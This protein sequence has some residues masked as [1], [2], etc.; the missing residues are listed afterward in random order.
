MN[1]VD[2]FESKRTGSPCSREERADETPH[3]PF[4]LLHTYEAETIFATF[5]T[6]YNLMGWGEWN[7]EGLESRRFTED[8]MSR[9]SC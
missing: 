9:R 7:S 4:Q 8:D 2:E 3:A 5:Q 1:L 6:Y